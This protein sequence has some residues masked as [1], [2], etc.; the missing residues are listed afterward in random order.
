MSK[1]ITALIML[2]KSGT[3]KS[4]LLVHNA[5]RKSAIHTVQKLTRID[6]VKNIIVAVPK[7][8]KA[9]W[10]EDAY[11]K[12]VSENV[13]WEIDP[14]NR[15]FHFGNRISEIALKHNLKHVLYI[16][17]G[18]MPLLK[19]EVLEEI[20]DK[21]MKSRGK[22]ALTNNF[23]SSDWL[24]ITDGSAL[25]MLTKFLPRD[26]MLG[27]VLQ[28]KGGFIVEALPPSAGTQLDIDTP[29]DLVAMRWHPDTPADM[30]SF[31][32]KYLPHEPLIRWQ[33]AA[34]KLNT[35]GSHVALIGRVSP[36][37]WQMMQTNLEVWTRVFSEERVMTSSGR[38]GGGT[39]HS[40]LGHYIDIL[41]ANVLFDKLDE[42]VNVGFIDS[43][44]YMAHIGVWPTNSD[45]YASDLLQIREIKNDKLR[46][47]TQAALE[48][49]SPMILGAYGCVSGGLYSL[50][51][52]IKTKSIGQ[53]ING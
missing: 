13:N 4:E 27:W 8:E 53:S 36:Y 50:V 33:E 43:R 18:S 15:P 23:H 17:G 32:T 10:G 31:L 34:H 12:K 30:R 42:M 51:E 7:Q 38:W 45:R 25:P 2:G 5:R 11:F 37:L 46:E 40:L 24:G 21:I 1:N 52:T 16:G 41:G 39:V 3:S 26:N 29:T 35:P 48:C 28:N 19:L 49:H 9:I 22:Y 6:N 44:V 20:V 47:F 14:A